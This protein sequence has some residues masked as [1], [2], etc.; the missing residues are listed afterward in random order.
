[1]KWRHQ[2]E[3]KKKEEQA[4]LLS[5]SSKDDQ[6]AVN[7]T[8]TKCTEKQNASDIGESEDESECAPLTS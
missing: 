3:V 5:N 1:M 8:E 7:A 2:K 6:K 4:K